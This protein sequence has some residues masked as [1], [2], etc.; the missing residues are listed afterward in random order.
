[1]RADEMQGNH[2]YSALIDQGCDG[3]GL[4][5]SLLLIKLTS[6]LHWKLQYFSYRKKTWMRTVLMLPEL[7]TDFSTAESPF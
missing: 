4:T 6:G 2:A 5:K 3:K 7:K 1:M